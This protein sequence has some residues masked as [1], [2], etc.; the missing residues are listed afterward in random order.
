MEGKHAELK[1]QILT[2]KGNLLYLLSITRSQRE[3][4][5]RELTVRMAEEMID[6]GGRLPRVQQVIAGHVSLQVQAMRFVQQQYHLLQ[7]HEQH[8]QPLK[9]EAQR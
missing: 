6:I 2:A 7:S 8:E 1:K 3:H 9:K 5:R 4:E